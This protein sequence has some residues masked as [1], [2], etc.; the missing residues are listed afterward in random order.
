MVTHNP[1]LAEQYATRI[2]TLRDG[3]IRS[4][5]DPYEVDE[6][7]AEPPKHKNMGK[8]SMSF[9]TALALSF[10]NLKTKKAR[11]LLTAFAGSIGIIGIAL[12]LSLSN[13]VNE[14]I[15]NVEEETLSEYP[16]QIQSTGFDITS[17]MVGNAS[18]MAADD[19]KD[20]ADNEDGKV[21][22]MQLVTNM[23]STMDSNDLKSLKEYLDEGKSGIEKY[24]NAVEYSYSVTPQIFKEEKD[25]VRQVHPDQSF[26]SL[27]LG[28]SSSSNS[29]MS[30][31]MSTDVFFEMPE[32]RSL[33][34]S[35]YDVKAGKWPEKYNECVLVLSS[36]GSISDFVAYTL[37][38][39]DPLELD[40]MIRQFMNEETIDV[41]SDFQ[42]YSYDQIVGTTFKLVN[43]SDFYEYD[44]QYKVWKD[45]T[46]NASYMKKL[47]EN[48]ETI[49]IVGVVQPREGAAASSLNPGI[50][51][52]A[53]LTRYVA[54]QA[55]D[56]EIVKQQLADAGVNVFTNKKFGEEDGESS[57]SE[58]SLFTV[59]EAALQKAFKMDESV[60]AGLGTAS[61]FS[62]VFTSG[63]NALDLSGM[64]DS[65]SLDLNLDG[66]PAMDLQKLLKGIKVEVSSDGMQKLSASMLEGYQE[67]AKTHPEADYSNL[68]EDLRNYLR[69]ETA[70]KILSDNLKEILRRSQSQCRTDTGTAPKSHVRLSGVPH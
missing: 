8:S 26:S 59:D 51:Y 9:L 4:D 28:S 19:E 63:G 25:G 60:L 49:R 50:C 1:E 56:S 3:K 6:T 55:A 32:T 14:Y 43:S 46:D 5:T 33:Y 21:K 30:S 67:Y 36:N 52:P 29:I 45:K 39:R 16:L 12:I 54:E 18:E 53:S 69:S 11:T 66:L 40:E 44:S 57:F 37:G 22:V 47:V 31:M 17:M 23:F 38:L 65:G 68:Q 42:D 35:Q 34:E 13:G 10:N 70:R 7:Q 2:V 24:T 58:D 15:Q 27:G 20:T 64:M 41:P 48:G 62:G 61:D